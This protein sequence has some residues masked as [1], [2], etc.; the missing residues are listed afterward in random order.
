MNLGQIMRPKRSQT[1]PITQENRQMKL[2]SQTFTNNIDVPG[3]T[4]VILVFFLF[5]VYICRMD[6]TLSCHTVM[7]QRPA[8]H[9]TA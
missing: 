5:N 6:L 9:H 3:M 7:I 1:G 2:A 4:P 8:F